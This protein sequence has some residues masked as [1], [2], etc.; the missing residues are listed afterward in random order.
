VN[1]YVACD[2]TEGG[3]HCRITVGDDPEAT[4][5]EVIVAADDLVHLGPPGVTPE[6]LVEESFAF[7]LE[8]EPRE[9][10]LREFEITMIGRYFPEFELE[11]RQQLGG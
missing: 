8:R 4:S 3:W 2:P 6:L 11:I 10:I 5:H 7:L 9:A 1:V